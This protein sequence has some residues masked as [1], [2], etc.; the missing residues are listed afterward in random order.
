MVEMLTQKIETDGFLTELVEHSL[1]ARITNAIKEVTT[2]I[3]SGEFRSGLH[4]K[5]YGDAHRLKEY[6]EGLQ[7]LLKA[8]P[9]PEELKTA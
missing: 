4:D 3:L 8:I 7:Q 5:P 9:S 2:G 6:R 1:A